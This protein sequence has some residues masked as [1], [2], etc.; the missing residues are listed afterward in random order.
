L[1]AADFA[2]FAA[3]QF[4]LSAVQDDGEPLR[5]HLMA[6]WRQTGKMPKQLEDAPPLP[7]H[8]EAIWRTFLELHAGRG[9]TGF[10][11]ARLAYNDFD[12]YQRVTGQRLSAWEIAMIRSAD[13]AYL[14]SLP[15]K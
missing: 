15:A 9:N 8:C 12:G 7:D 4:E 2:E 14:A 13:S 11:P 5:E 6:A 3:A 10:G 1:I